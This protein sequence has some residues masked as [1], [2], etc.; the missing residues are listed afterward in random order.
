MRSHPDFKEKYSENTDSQNREI[1][2]L[3]IFDDVMSKQRKI[4][5][6]LYKMI[7]KDESFKVAMQALKRLLSAS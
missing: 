5:L 6:D 1:A 7:T 2:F 3:K 4:E